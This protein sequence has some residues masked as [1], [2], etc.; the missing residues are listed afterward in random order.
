[1]VGFQNSMR[2]NSWQKPKSLYEMNGGGHVYQGDFDAYDRGQEPARRA[3]EEGLKALL[4]RPKGKDGKPLKEYG[5]PVP[6]DVEELAFKAY[7]E[8]LDNGGTGHH[9]IGKEE[10]HDILRDHSSW[11]S[12]S[13]SARD[14][15]V[16]KFMSILND[17]HAHGIHG[18]R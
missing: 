15:A 7:K 4:E 8:F 10:A 5:I 6:S 9:G 11:R 1:M 16:G 17:I 13:D 12:L 3:D 14:T 18:K 2:K